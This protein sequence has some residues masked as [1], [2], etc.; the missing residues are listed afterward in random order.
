MADYTRDTVVT[1]E[2]LVL[3]GAV[4]ARDPVYGTLSSATQ[5]TDGD[6]LAAGGGTS[7]SPLKVKRGG[8]WAQL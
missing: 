4:V 6:P 2:P 8:A 3:A 1:P 5:L 7:P